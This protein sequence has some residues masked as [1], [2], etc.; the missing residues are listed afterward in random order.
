MD[1]VESQ[2]LTI[3]RGVLGD[4]STQHL[5]EHSALLGSIAEVDSMAVVAILAA[6]EDEFGFSVADDEIDGAAFASVAS[7]TA[8]VRSKLAA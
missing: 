1:Q 3:L 7:L 4:A 5:N 6:V 2:V 8:F